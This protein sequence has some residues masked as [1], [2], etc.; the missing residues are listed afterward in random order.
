MSTGR[1][2]QKKP[3]TRPRKSGLERRRRSRLQRARLITLGISEGVVAKMNQKEVRT[4]LSRPAQLA[5]V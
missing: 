3:M 2:Y 4:L 5:A 1:K